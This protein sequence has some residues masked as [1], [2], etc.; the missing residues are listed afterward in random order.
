[1]TAHVAVWHFSVVDL[2]GSTAL[3]LIPCRAKL[4]LDKK[5]SETIDPVQPLMYVIRSRPPGQII[6]KG[7]DCWTNASQ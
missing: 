5:E 3:N 4:R 7:W 2:Q 1:M 6:L